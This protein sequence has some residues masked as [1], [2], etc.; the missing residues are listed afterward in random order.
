MVKRIQMTLI[1]GPFELEFRAELIKPGQR[2]PRSS[3]YRCDSYYITP[4]VKISSTPQLCMAVT[5]KRW[6]YTPQT[7]EYCRIQDVDNIIIK[8]GAATI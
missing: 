7:I 4:T 2:N 1:R 6:K 5:A 3:S 8:R